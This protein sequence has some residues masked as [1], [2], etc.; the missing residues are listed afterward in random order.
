MAQQ[1]AW[2]RQMERLPAAVVGADAPAVKRRCHAPRQKPVGR[3]QGRS[4][5]PFQCV[6][7]DQRDG[8]GLFAWIGRRDQGQIAGGFGQKRKIFPLAHPLIGDRCGTHCQRNECIAIRRLGARICPE[9]YITR[10]QAEAIHQSL[11]AILR[12]IFGRDLA[13]AE[14]SPARNGHIEVK[15]RQDDRPI[16]Q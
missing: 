8:Q 2:G 16:R 12:M 7:Q 9:L 14:T 13:R 3:D 11:E 4:L 5:A 6:A 15:P 10:A 1:P